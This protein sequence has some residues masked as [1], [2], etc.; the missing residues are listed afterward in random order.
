[1]V[2]G[3]HHKVLVMLLVVVEMHMVMVP[4]AVPSASSHS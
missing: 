1:M 2:V 3:G 4:M